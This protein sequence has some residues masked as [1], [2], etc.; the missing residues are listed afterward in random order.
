MWHAKNELIKNL[1][2]SSKE[3]RHLKLLHCIWLDEFDNNNERRIMKHSSIMIGE[4]K[5][6]DNGYI[7]KQFAKNFMEKI[8]N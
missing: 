4:R 2:S 5:W 1:I 7:W 8:N 6:F 3:I